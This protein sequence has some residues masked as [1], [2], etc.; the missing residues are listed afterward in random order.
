MEKRKHMTEIVSL[1]LTRSEKKI[2]NSLASTE[3]LSQT[4][5]L[6]KK[7]RGL[8]SESQNLKS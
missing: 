8:I 1:R 2:L 6:R 4:E 3:R 7:I 5:F